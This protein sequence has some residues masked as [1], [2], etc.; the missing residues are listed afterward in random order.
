MSCIEDRNKELEL[1]LSDVIDPETGLSVM[2]MDLIDAVVVGGTG[3]VSLVFRP[4]SPARPMAYGLANSR[5]RRILEL[6]WVSSVSMKVEDHM[7]SDHLESL[8]NI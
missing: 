6:E 5:K 8:T 1:E 7:R 4:S 2:K 3:A